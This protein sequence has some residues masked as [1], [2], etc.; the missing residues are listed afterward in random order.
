MREVRP[1]LRGR[2]L[3]E[4]VPKNDD[5]RACSLLKI[6]NRQPV[7]RRVGSRTACGHFTAVL[8]A[9]IE[10]S[11]I[12]GGGNRTAPRAGDRQH[13][14]G[15]GRA[16]GP[17]GGGETLRLGGSGSLPGVQPR[18]P[19]RYR[20]GR[21]HL[22]ARRPARLRRVAGPARTRRRPRRGRMAV[23]TCRGA[24]PRRHARAMPASAALAGRIVTAARPVGEGAGGARRPLR[25]APR[26]PKVGVRGGGPPPPPVDRPWGL[27]GRL[28]GPHPIPSRGAGSG[29]VVELAFAPRPPPALRRGWPRLRL[30]ACGDGITICP[31]DALVCSPGERVD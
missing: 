4:H 14:L 21:R 29:R 19:A 2:D 22:R 15:P 13:R 11:R 16:A 30:Q 27:G 20:R 31:G 3:H 7:C 18:P 24:G 6:P 10:D 17:G 12:P 26:R 28:P 1:G 25:A 23:A 5:A 9:G 8:P